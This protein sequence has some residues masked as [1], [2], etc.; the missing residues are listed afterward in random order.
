MGL[1]SSDVPF[2]PKSVP[3]FYGWA[4]VVLAALGMVASIPGQTAG[5][6]AFTDYWMRDAG[7]KRSQLSHAYLVGTII[8]AMMLPAGGRLVDRIG[9]RKS[10]LIA[11]MTLACSM[12]FMSELAVL[13]RWSLFVAFGPFVV[14]VIAFVGM[15]FG[16]QGL[17]ITVCQT[18]LGRWFDKKR[19]LASGINSVLRATAF[20][21]APLVFGLWVQGAGSWRTAY[22]QIAIMV[23]FAA[24]FMIWFFYRDSPEACGLVVDGGAG[25]EVVRQDLVTPSGTGQLL[26]GVSRAEALTTVAFW[27]AGGALA[28][29]AF[30]MTGITFH[31]TDVGGRAGLGRQESLAMLL[32]TGIVAWVSSLFLGF[33]L[34][35]I[36]A[37]VLVVTMYLSQACGAALFPFIHLPVVRWLAIAA[38]G[39]SGGCFGLMSLAIFPRFFGRRELGAIQGASMMILVLASALGPSAFAEAA[40]FFDGY[41][42][43]LIAC[44]VISFFGMLAGVF[45][46]MHDFSGRDSTGA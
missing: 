7:L 26:E 19:G 27:V 2:A 44:A 25:S 36:P 35:R 46:T 20:G 30:L 29:Q 17:L 41:T 18:M 42:E 28:I 23:L 31:I 32:P 8:S 10:G 16:G 12:L 22:Q 33:L 1:F 6:S 5:V 40:D 38:V 37:R 13:C 39:I 4:L 3:F 24:G 15:R 11:V 14:L 45:A 34:D 21:A 9:V 43:I